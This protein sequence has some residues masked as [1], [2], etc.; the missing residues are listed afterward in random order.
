ME[1]QNYTV[2]GTTIMHDGK[3]YA[4]G[5]PIALTEEEAL[6][7]GTMVTASAVKAFASPKGKAKA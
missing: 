5:K 7:L 6:A 3:R 4:P 2:G 1:T